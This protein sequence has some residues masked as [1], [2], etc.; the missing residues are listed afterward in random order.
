MNNID[1]FSMKRYKITDNGEQ[2]IRLFV[3]YITFHLLS[4]PEKTL[5]LII[6]TLSKDVRSQIARI[7][8][9]LSKLN[10]KK[11]VPYTYSNNH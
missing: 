4:F 5:L 10:L 7:Y 11:I 1:L 6:F 8:C 2:R 9:I 3:L